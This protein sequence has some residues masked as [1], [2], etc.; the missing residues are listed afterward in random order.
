MS[1]QLSELTDIVRDAG[2]TLLIPG[3]DNISHSRKEDGGIVTKIDT[4]TQEYLSHRL[5]NLVPGSLVLGEEMTDAQH[6]AL[7]EH[8]QSQPDLGLWIID[9]LD[10][11]RNYAA[12]IPVFCVSVAWY[13]NGQVVL[14]VV[15][16]P[17]RDECF[18]AEY[19]RGAWLNDTPLQ[20]NDSTQ[21]LKHS[22]AVIDTKR[23]THQLSTSLMRQ[24]PYASMRSFGSGALEWCWL[25][26]QRFQL[27]LHGSQKLWDYAAG[28]LILREAGGHSVSLDTQAETNTLQLT[29]S[30]LAASNQSLFELWQNWLAANQ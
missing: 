10:G 28:E 2:Q 17:M 13:H 6:N 20:L 18:A 8:Y 12:G 5:K 1:P 7:L 30:F 16:D 25:A 19:S 9:P 21:Q 4:E 15:Y 26:A 24:S 23:L 14:G 22:I 29:S 11:T 3:F 27:Y